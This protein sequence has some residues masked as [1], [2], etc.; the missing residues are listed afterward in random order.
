MIDVELLLVGHMDPPELATSGSAAVDLRIDLS[1]ETTAMSSNPNVQFQA[2]GGDVDPSLVLQ[3]VTNIMVPTN[4]EG[5]K[6][7]EGYAGLVQP[8]SGLAA[9]SNLTVLNSPGLIDSDYRGPVNVI[10]QHTPSI[11][12]AGLTIRHGD[13]IAQLRFVEVPKVNLISV[14][15]LS[16]DDFE[17]ERGDGGFGSTGAN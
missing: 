10:L 9:R 6:I 13:R 4:V 16:A 12:H 5:I 7:P 14:V 2:G 11:S 8:R 15:E 1:E 3:G 17:N